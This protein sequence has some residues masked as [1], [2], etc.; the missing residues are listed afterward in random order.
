MKCEEMVLLKEIVVAIFYHTTKKATR[1][2]KDH[3][4][5]RI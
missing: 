1:I 2:E 3:K 4:R 5:L